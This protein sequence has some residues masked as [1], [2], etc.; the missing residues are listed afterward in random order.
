MVAVSLRW[1]SSSTSLALSPTSSA[2]CKSWRAWKSSDTATSRALL[3]AERA[4]EASLVSFLR[5]A[6]KCWYAGTQLPTNTKR[7]RRHRRHGRR[8]S[9]FRLVR[10]L[11]SGV[12]SVAA[13]CTPQGFQEGRRLVLC[14]QNKIKPRSTHTSSRTSIPL[15]RS[16]APRTRAVEKG[17]NRLDVRKC[18]RFEEER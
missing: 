8:T 3:S 16:R 5:S 17:V 12:M 7:T 15:S 6:L 11:V 13:R 9:G 1:R 10:L 14:G 18:V 2:C 4:A